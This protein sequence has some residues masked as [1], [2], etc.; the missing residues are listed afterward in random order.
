MPRLDWQM[1]FAALSLPPQWFIAFL[2]RLLEGSPEVLA[3]LADNPFPDA[4]P[5]RVR[6]TLYRYHMTR[7]KER[8]ESGCWWKRERLGLYV[9]PLEK[10]PGGLQLARGATL[11]E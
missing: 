7:W 9:P 4:P 8:R 1:W 5:R 6:A 11:L 3:L 2:E 10:G